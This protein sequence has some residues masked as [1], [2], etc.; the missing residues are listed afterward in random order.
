M[1]RG[2]GALLVAVLLA[3]RELAAF[4]RMT[5]IDSLRQ[6]AVSARLAGDLAAA[7][8]T[9]A[10]LKSL[11]K[12]RAV[13][14]CGLARFDEQQAEIF[15]ADALLGLAETEILGPLDKA[16]LTEIET[17]A[18]QVA[19]VTA[20]VPIALADVATA[21]FANL[22]M[23]RRLSQLYGGRSS[24]LGNLSL[25]RRV[26]SALLGA[27]AIALADDLIGSFAS[28]G[29]LAKLSRRFG[30]GVVNGALTARVGLAAME[31]CRPLP[32]AALEKPG[33]TATISRALAGYLNRAKAESD[34][35]R[36]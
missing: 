12:G 32:F 34:E 30:E 27:G 22:R 20:L 8:A 19:T 4:A 33:T 11:Y 13:A 24:T 31:A 3:L 36:S 21:L 5:R 28:G 7:R 9:V 6:K 1:G 35:P 14:A 29:I 25:L 10:A 15:D 16:A 17:A 23:I 2:G 26:F 18:R